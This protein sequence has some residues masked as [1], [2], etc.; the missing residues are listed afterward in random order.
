M[1]SPLLKMAE[2]PDGKHFTLRPSDNNII[3]P[4]ECDELRK[5]VDRVQRECAY[6]SDAV[7]KVKAIAKDVDSG[8][9]VAQALRKAR[10][11]E[12]DLERDLKVINRAFTIYAKDEAGEW[13]EYPRPSSKLV[14][15]GI[16]VGD[17]AIADDKGAFKVEIDRTLTVVQ[18]VLSAEQNL[19]QRV[20]HW[21]PSASQ[22]RKTVRLSEYIRDLKDICHVGLEHDD[23][24]QIKLASKSLESFREEFV[25]KEAG[26]VKNNY[27]WRLGIKCLIISVISS[28]LYIYA[29]VE[30]HTV[31]PHDT[32]FH[33]FRNFFLLAAGAGVGT[34]LSFALRRPILTFLDLAT[35][36][37]D[38]L[39][40]S[41][42]ALYVTALSSIVGLLFWTQT[43]VIS[44]IGIFTTK[45]FHEHGATALLIG[46]VLGVAERTMATAV[47]KRATELASGIGGK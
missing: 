4:P 33:A 32:V 6:S 9:D 31:L 36:E 34:W 23:P 19:L 42:R 30:P 26:N 8:G 14:D 25:A 7:S 27:L 21:R 2:E 39:G 16:R 11:V 18:V 24:S 41:L 40:T 38:R 35:L 28:I 3:L 37:E 47:Q 15:L 29:R 45:D 5:L 43:I 20:L 12:Q 10:S 17:A 1:A 22:S 46:L 13:L 44:G